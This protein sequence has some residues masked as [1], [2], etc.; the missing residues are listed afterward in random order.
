MTAPRRPQDSKAGRATPRADAL[1]G[2]RKRLPARGLRICLVRRT[3]AQSSRSPEARAASSG[4][5]G[6]CGLLRIHKNDEGHDGRF[7]SS[8][9]SPSDLTNGPRDRPAPPGL[10]NQRRATTRLPRLSR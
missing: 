5:A 2:P 9:P 10:F 3:G 8:P 4:K 7:A 1:Q 6:H